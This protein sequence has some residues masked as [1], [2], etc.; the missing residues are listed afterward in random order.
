MVTL[1]V[2]FGDPNPSNNPSFYILRYLSHLC[3]NI[4]DFKFGVKVDHSKSQL[5]DYKLSRKGR[6][7]VM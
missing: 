6:G 3:V 4:R 1:P 5:I 7:P 2:T